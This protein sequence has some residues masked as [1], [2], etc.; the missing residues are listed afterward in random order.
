MA[1]LDVQN[2]FS[3]KQALAQA[4]GSYLSTNTIDLGAPGTDINGN[5]AP[6]DP[7]QSR[8]GI[9]ARVTEAFTSAGAATVQAQL[10]SADDAA[11]G[12]NLTVLQQ[13]DVI[14]KATL[15]VG[16]KFEFSTLPAVKQRYLGMRYVIGTATTTAGKI[17]SGVV[18]TQQAA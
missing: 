1:L 9:F 2:L 11:L 15:V 10:V 6:S 8:V 18:I 7:G 5:T 13:T 3:D 17:S 12:T 16:Y 4:A 14:P